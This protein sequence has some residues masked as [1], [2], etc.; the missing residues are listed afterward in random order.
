MVL[1]P[2]TIKVLYGF[3]VHPVH[4]KAG[5]MGQIAGLHYRARS[6]DV[7]ETQNMANLMNCHLIDRRVK[8]LE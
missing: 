3:P 6:V 1:L 4:L 2:C 8:I 5:L 7:G